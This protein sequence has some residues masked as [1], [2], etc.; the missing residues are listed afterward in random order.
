M[1]GNA[2]HSQNIS[3]LRMTFIN[4]SSIPNNSR[5]PSKFIYVWLLLVL[6]APSHTVALPYKPETPVIYSFHVRSSYRWQVIPSS[7]W[8]VI[9]GKFIS[10]LIFVAHA[11]SGWPEGSHWLLSETSWLP[12]ICLSTAL[13]HFFL[14]IPLYTLYGVYHLHSTTKVLF[15]K[16]PQTSVAYDNKH[17]FCSCVCGVQRVGY[18]HWLISPGLAHKLVFK[19]G[20]PVSTVA[21]VKAH[22]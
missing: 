5:K 16:Q 19:H 12:N 7:W 2:H 10:A 6:P 18:E 3:F 13:C 14:F 21:V 1:A 11:S 4:R 15:Y 22:I 20:F 8:H 9:I 17:L